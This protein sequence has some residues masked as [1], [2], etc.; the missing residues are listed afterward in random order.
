MDLS[1]LENLNDKGRI[2]GYVELLLKYLAQMLN[3]VV[4]RNW[5]EFL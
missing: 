3:L 5:F 2:F 4:M 1:C